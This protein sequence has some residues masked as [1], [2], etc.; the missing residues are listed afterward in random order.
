MNDSI[1][2]FNEDKQDQIDRYLKGEMSEQECSIFE[3]TLVDDKTLNEQFVYSKLVQEVISSRSAKLEKISK[4]ENMAIQNNSSSLMNTMRDHRLWPYRWVAS[5]LLVFSLGIF[6]INYL[7][8]VLYNV[9]DVNQSEPTYNKNIA[10]QDN[11]QSDS[12]VIDS[13]TV[14]PDSII[15]KK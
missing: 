15:Y 4:W 13:L 14:T 10:P 12:I 8:D 1:I 2:N 11:S 9:D 6:G 3:Q 7:L 5:I